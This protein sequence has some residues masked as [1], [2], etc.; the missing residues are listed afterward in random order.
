MSVLAGH[1][2]LNTECCLKL[3]VTML[4]LILHLDTQTRS[5]WSAMKCVPHISV[6]EVSVQSCQ[7]ITAWMDDGQRRLGN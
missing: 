2:G 1:E 4:S 7:Y 6:S 5:N 3:S